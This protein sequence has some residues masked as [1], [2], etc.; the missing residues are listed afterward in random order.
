MSSGCSG[1]RM[2]IMSQNSFSYNAGLK[3]VWFV[4][5]CMF[6]YHGLASNLINVGLEMEPASGSPTRLSAEWLAYMRPKTWT[7]FI[8]KMV[9]LLKSVRYFLYF[10]IEN[11]QTIPFLELQ[12][13]GPLSS[14]VT[15]LTHSRHEKNK[16]E[17]PDRAQR[18]IY[19]CHLL[20]LREQCWKPTLFTP[21][22][23]QA[24]EQNFSLFKTRITD[25]FITPSDT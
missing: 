23:C 15:V 14:C 13:L 11:S 3:L 25:H 4:V 6:W 2:Y 16:H 24:H 12:R 9:S 1:E 7:M 5:C 20:N 8:F 22:L 21:T 10:L 19:L 17:L 18:L